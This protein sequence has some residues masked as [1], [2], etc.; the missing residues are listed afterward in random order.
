MPRAAKCCAEIGCTAI[1]KGGNR[2]PAHAKTWTNHGVDRSDTKARRRMR[3]AVLR[4]A[5]GRC[6]IG[7]PGCAGT[8]TQVDRL[9]G[10]VDYVDIDGL[11][12]ACQPCH[13]RRTSRQGNAAQG[14]RVPDIQPSDD[15][16]MRR[17]VGASKRSDAT[18][19]KTGVPRRIVIW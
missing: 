9:D 19:A 2:C 5:D 6:E 17:D 10:V 12:A 8:A 16:S 13:A 14:H 11:R 15:A 1:V 18:V 4:R 3:A 7:W